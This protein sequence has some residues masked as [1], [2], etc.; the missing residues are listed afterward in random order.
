M[1][2]GHL[3]GRP[4]KIEIISDGVSSPISEVPPPTLTLLNRLSPASNT[5]TTTTRSLT[6]NMNL[7]PDAATP[8]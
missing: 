5:L 8:T 2:T 1:Y 7:G 3:L 4:I 6:D